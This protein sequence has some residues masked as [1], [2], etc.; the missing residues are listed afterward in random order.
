M[1]FDCTLH[2]ILLAFCIKNRELIVSYASL[3]VQRTLLRTLRTDLSVSGF[4][5]QCLYL[6]SSKYHVFEY[7]IIIY[8]D[9]GHVSQVPIMLT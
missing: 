1:Q 6:M 2:N 5:E 9:V 4:S 8:W 7:L 3:Y